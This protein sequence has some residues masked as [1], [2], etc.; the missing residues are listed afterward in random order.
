MTA[1]VALFRLHEYRDRPAEALK[2][3][4]SLEAAWPDIAFCTGG[5]RVELAL[6]TAPDDPATLAEA[7]AWCQAFISSPAEEIPLPGMGPFGAAEAY[8]IANL[9]WAGAQIAL[10]KFPAAQLYLKRQ[11]VRAE[12]NGLTS[13]V[14]EMSILEAL[15]WSAAGDGQASFKALERALAAAQPEGYL[16]IFDQGPA[17]S[18]LLVAAA[19]RGR[20]QDYIGQILAATHSEEALNPGRDVRYAP[21]G[22]SSMP[23]PAFNLESGEHLSQ[24][25]LEVLRL[26][27]RGASNQAIAQQLVITVGT[28]K[29]HINHILG[30]LGAGNRT[31]AVALARG[32][33][34]LDF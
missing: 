10:G 19:Q 12:T 4:D 11:L 29:S 21:V 30:K 6:R 17:L 2:C 33:G 16:R 23:A 15:A 1:C 13:R 20:F 24:R 26:I 8:Y 22:G 3:L 31:E 34:W 27:A 5:L 18:N 25:E 9:A 14:I 7:A 32:L 28:V